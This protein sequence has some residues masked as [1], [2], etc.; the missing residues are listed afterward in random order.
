MID[1]IDI[2]LEKNLSVSIDINSQETTC[3]SGYIDKQ[4]EPTIS[5]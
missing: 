3:S 5:G 1:D 2:P 4:W